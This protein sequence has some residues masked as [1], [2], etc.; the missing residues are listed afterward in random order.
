MASEDVVHEK[1][2]QVWRWLRVMGVPVERPGDGVSDGILELGRLM[3]SRASREPWRLEPGRQRPI[4][5][6]R[7]LLHPELTGPHEHRRSEVAETGQR[8]GD[9]RVLTSPLAQMV[10]AAAGLGEGL[11]FPGVQAIHTRWGPVPLD[12][13]F[14]GPD[15]R[16]I[17]TAGELP[18][19]V[20]R[21]AAGASAVIELPGGTIKRLG[22]S[23][24]QHLR[25]QPP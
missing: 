4:D 15:D 11:L 21:Q 3:V 24:G 25:L 2:V 17:G 16:V 23:P 12:V 5:H 7:L 6:L 10:G 8:V 1:V 13:L 20:A 22:I 14:L 9:L 19:G 18:R